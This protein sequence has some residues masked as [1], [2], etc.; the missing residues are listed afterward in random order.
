MTKFLLSAITVFVAIAEFSAGTCY[1]FI[2]GQD[3][4]P[5]ELI[6]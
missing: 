1:F 5:E 3:E 4:M 6:D 2:F